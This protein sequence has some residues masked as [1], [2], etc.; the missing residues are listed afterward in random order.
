[1]R[2]GWPHSVKIKSA[3]VPA[4]SRVAHTPL[5]FFPAPPSCR[6]FRKFGSDRFLRVEVDANVTPDAFQTHFCGT[7][8][9]CL[10]GRLWQ[11]LYFKPMAG[12]L[13]LVEVSDGSD[14][15]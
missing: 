2:R 13:T 7:A 6:A 5:R 14:G 1:M 15:R 9:L 8:P 12:L 4:F 3:P 10:A 11:L